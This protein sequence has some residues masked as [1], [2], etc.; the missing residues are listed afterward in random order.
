MIALFTRFILMLA[1]LGT[2]PVAHGSEALKQQ[3]L[4][5]LQ[6]INARNPARS[7]QYEDL[8]NIRDDKILDSTNRVVGEVNDILLSQQGNIEYMNID[9]NRLKL[10][11][12]SLFMAYGRAG[13]RPVSNGYKM[14]LSDDDIRTQLPTILAQTASAAGDDQDIYSASKIPGAPVFAQNGAQLGVVKKV[15]FEGQG[16]YAELL[17]IDYNHKRTR[18]R[19]MAIRFNDARFDASGNALRIN[20]PVALAEAMEDFALRRD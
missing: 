20:V 6:E 14:T 15:L 12:D 2:A 13:M 10:G 4:Q 3:Y 16:R 5:E 1:L 19:D 11:T 17:Y 18:G 7:S 8:A 9:F